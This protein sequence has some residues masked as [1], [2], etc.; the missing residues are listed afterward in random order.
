LLIATVLVETT[1]M[2]ASSIDTFT[3][4]SSEFIAGN[5]QPSGHRRAQ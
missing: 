3:E 4:L 1:I 5:R 2:V